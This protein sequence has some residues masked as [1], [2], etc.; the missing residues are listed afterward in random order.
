MTD[1]LFD[2]K[3][4][5]AP[6]VLRYLVRKALQLLE[7]RSWIQSYEDAICFAAVESVV[8]GAVVVGVV[9]SEMV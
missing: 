9:D 3:T 4:I 2:E 8:G 7:S 6:G 5:V 1:P